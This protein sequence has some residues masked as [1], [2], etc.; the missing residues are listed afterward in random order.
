[1]LQALEDVLAIKLYAKDA[2]VG[3]SANENPRQDQVSKGR[4]HSPGSAPTKA[5]ILGELVSCTN[6]FT[7]PE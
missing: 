6:D 1:M 5:L 2:K 7:T 4:V 3:S